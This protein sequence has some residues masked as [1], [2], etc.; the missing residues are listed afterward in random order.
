MSERIVWLDWMKVF[1]ILAV[2]WGHFFSEGHVYL[3]VF[4]VQAFCLISGFLYK[5]SPSWSDCLKRVFWNLFLP[6][7][8]FSIVMHAEAWLRCLSLGQDYPVSLPWF[9]GML[10]SGHRWCMGPCWFFYSLMVIRLIMQLLPEKRW[11][12]ALVF[13]F[14]ATATIALHHSGLQVSNAN[15]NALLVMPFFLI[16]VF[17]KPLTPHLSPLPPHLSPL[18]L[19]VSGLLVYLCGRWNGDVWMYLAEYGNSY[20]LYI[21]GGVAGTLMLFFLSQLACTVSHLSPHT[22]HLSPHTSHLTPHT[23][24]PSPLSDLVTTLSK[25]SLL[26]IGLHI[27]IVRR[28]TDLPDR[29]WLEDLLWSVLILLAFIPVVRLAERFC[30]LL[31]G[32]QAQSMSGKKVRR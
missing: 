17:L 32:R 9:F 26:I 1:A 3:Y 6:T 25:G 2:V 23:S 24:Y 19:L 15:V 18:L 5:K 22:S 28:L 29:L 31:I 11:V 20:I 21:I 8:I 4:H 27:I 12:Y 13:L 14:C 16:G 10:L 30:P 7:V